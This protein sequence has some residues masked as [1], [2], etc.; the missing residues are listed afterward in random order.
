MDTRSIR[1]VYQIGLLEFGILLVGKALS[2][3][4]RGYSRNGRDRD[5][6]STA[7]SYRGL[8]SQIRN[9]L[10]ATISAF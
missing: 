9:P 5:K 2:L 4:D 8:S 1:I 3:L 6:I 10:I 7:L